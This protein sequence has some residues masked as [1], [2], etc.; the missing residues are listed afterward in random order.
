MTAHSIITA[1]LCARGLLPQTFTC[2]CCGDTLDRD[3]HMRD[4][5]TD[6]HT[7]AVQAEYG[8]DVCFGC[9][10]DFTPPQP[11]SDCGR[12]VCTCD[13]AYD[14]WVEERMT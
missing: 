7:A 11:C 1:A 12:D 10:D 3:D 13:D 6:E 8:P 4:R 5:F 2:A 14:R 9:A